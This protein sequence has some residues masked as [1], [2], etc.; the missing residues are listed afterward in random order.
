MPQATGATKTVATFIVNAPTRSLPDWTLREAKRTLLNVLGIS[1]S[2][3]RYEPAARML[4]WVRRQ[5]G[6]GRA[7][8]I[9]SGGRTGTYYAALV[10]GYLAHLEDY[11]DTHLPTVL[12]PSAPVWPAVLAVAEDSGAS[13]LDTLAAF[14]I[15]AEVACRVA[16][17]THPKHYDL[18]WH[19][20]GTAGIFGSAAGASR[21]LG[22]GAEAAAD[23]LGVAGTH[24]S[25]VREMLGTDA[26]ALHPR[27]RR[28]PGRVQAAELSAA[29]FS[30]PADIFGGR[31]GFWAVLAPEGHFQ[32]RLTGA[33]GEHWELANNGLKPYANGVVSHPIQD[34]VIELRNAHAITPEQ[35]TAI[36]LRVH[37][38][39]EELMGRP[40]V[41]RG[42]E[43]KF[44]YR[45]CAA[46]ALAD[47]AG[48]DAQFTDAKVGRPRYRAAPRHHRN[49]GRRDRRRGPGTRRHRP[50]RWAHG[51]D[52][53]GA[54]HRLAPKPHVGRDA[55]AQVQRPCNGGSSP[56]TGQR[57]AGS[58]VA[59]GRSAQRRR[60]HASHERRRR[61]GGLA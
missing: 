33:L 3:S 12:H 40:A 21:L 49:A 10:N 27:A 6:T 14:A 23:A 7:T 61:P 28:R 52:V 43:G 32:E 54:R 2:A 18:G 47:G 16:M 9:A 4:E 55:P 50:G 8:L 37:P 20:T 58:C 44:S 5:G 26:K 35:V 53:R 13:G 46:A 19:I 48:H 29:G 34:G 45:H 59:P 51:R 56:V 42:L 24:A 41:S 38:L 30:G 1:L 25:G 36:R 57:A 60:G 11:D 15:G 22:A 39:V 31:R 17:S